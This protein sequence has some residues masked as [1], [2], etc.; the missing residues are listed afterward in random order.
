M[1][2]SIIYGLAQTAGHSLAPLQ[3]LDPILFASAAFWLA[4][5]A[6]SLA[7]VAVRSALA[8]SWPFALC[9][10]RLQLREA[11]PQPL[12]SLGVFDLQRPDFLD[13]HHKDACACVSPSTLVGEATQARV[14]LLPIGEPV[15][16][17]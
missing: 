14:G 4:F 7:S 9:L 10:L 16:H 6:C 1:I 12:V 13:R 17:G 2:C 11:P 15:G 3:P 8:A 5:S